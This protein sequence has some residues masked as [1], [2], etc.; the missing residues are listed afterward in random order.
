MILVTGGTGLVG[1]YL[2]Q[3][4]TQTEAAVIAIY[5]NEK[6]IAKTKSFF[7]AGAH[8][9]NFNKITWLPASLEDIPA[10]NDT[11]KNVTQ[12]YHCA[13]LISFDPKDAKALHRVNVEGTANVVNLC[14]ANNVK[15]LCFVSS[16][17]AI[18]R[19]IGHAAANEQTD[20]PEQAVPEY[21]LTKY[22]A[23]LE[24]WRG[25]QEGLDVVIV[26]PGV[27]LGC[28]FWDNGSSKMFAFSAREPRYYLPG[29]TGF[30]TVNDVVNSMTLL[31]DSPITNE[32]Y[33]LVSK[34]LSYQ[35][36]SAL[37]AKGLQKKAPTKP[38][39]Q[40][41]L[42]VLWRLDWIRAT[43]FGQPRIL[44]RIMANGFKY[45]QTYDNSKLVKNTDFTYEEFEAY[46]LECCNAFKNKTTSSF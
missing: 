14:L 3:R 26:N 11:F 41:M 23:E 22:L 38:F 13:G 2:L 42:A 33:I 20:W 19:T 21:A 8:P 29:G 43:I 4:L 44:S 27:I 15:K 45:T 24:V 16:I 6:S 31:M 40:W 9:T 17:A 5:R 12:V 35:E 10:L 28:G 39:K 32:S 46:V 18:G 25:S 1:T 34:N 30:V 37:L 36:M 7:D